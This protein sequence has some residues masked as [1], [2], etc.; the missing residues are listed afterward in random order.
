[1]YFGPWN[2]IQVANRMLQD[3]VKRKIDMKEYLS[4]DII[5]V[6]SIE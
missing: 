4:A 3:K 1:M 2:D 6:T 5:K